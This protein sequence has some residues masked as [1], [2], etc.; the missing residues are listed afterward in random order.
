MKSSCAPC[1][2]QGVGRIDCPVTGASGP[3]DNTTVTSCAS[4]C[5][6]V[7]E[8]FCSEM[9][10]SKTRCSP[11]LHKNGDEPR[12]VHDSKPIAAED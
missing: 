3:E 12:R 10:G 2:L 6:A 7:L 11:H 4:Q 1:E 8:S 9:L 5:E